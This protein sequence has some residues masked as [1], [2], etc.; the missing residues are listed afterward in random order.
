LLNSQGEVE[1]PEV[2]DLGMVQGLRESLAAAIAEQNAIHID[3][4]KVERVGTPAVQV[5]LAAGRD[6]SAENRT[7][8]ITK[9]SDVFRSAFRDLGLDEQFSEWSEA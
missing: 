3:A 7:F 4:G 2:L 1:L 6:L 5:I 8:V 9:A